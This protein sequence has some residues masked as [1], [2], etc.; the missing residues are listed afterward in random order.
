LASL[1][2][3]TAAVQSLAAGSQSRASPIPSTTTPTARRQP[4]RASAS[5]QGANDLPLLG[6][7]RSGSRGCRCASDRQPLASRDV[8][9]GTTLT[10]ANPGTRIGTYGA[11]RGR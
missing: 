11:D 10:I 7:Q 9:A 5:L 3:D 4:H 6:G 1:A 8:D 2:N